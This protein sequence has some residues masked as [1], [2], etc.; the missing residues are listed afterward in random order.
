M[1]KG[2]TWRRRALE[3][4]AYALAMPGFLV[5]CWQILLVAGLVTIGPFRSPL[6]GT[7]KGMF[8]VGF[9]YYQLGWDFVFGPQ[10]VLLAALAFIPGV[11]VL[12][13]RVGS[14]W[15]PGSAVTV[16]QAGLGLS[17]LAVSYR[18]PAL[19]GLCLVL[20]W[21][22][23]ARPAIL[24]S[25]CAWALA[26]ALSLLP[27]DVSLQNLPGPARAAETAPCS[28]GGAYEA[29][30]NTTQEYV[31]RDWGQTLYRAPERVWVW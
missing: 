18:L 19:A 2:L 12:A 16:L 30:A 10:E 8:L 21:Q 13:R 28:T 24:S 9:A 17:V 1:S 25:W 7:E 14:R 22:L 29:M 15:S 31:C 11:W 5:V 26:M 23:V 3:S 6:V 20:V 4:G 27:V